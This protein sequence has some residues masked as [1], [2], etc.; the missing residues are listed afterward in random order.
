[1]T[2]K[3]GFTLIEVLISLGIFAYVFSS[4]MILFFQFSK[5]TT[6]E[7][8][9]SPFTLI[10]IQKILTEDMMM[11]VTSTTKMVLFDSET[12]WA[13]SNALYLFKNTKEDEFLRNK[14]DFQLDSCDVSFYINSNITAPL[15]NTSKCLD[16]QY[17]RGSSQ[18]ICAL[19]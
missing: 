3:R 6:G 4:L 9:C 8:K 12:L 1:M 16:F 5:N 11:Q 13:E 14:N 2:K 18:T 19:K 15:L 10:L 7:E 17:K